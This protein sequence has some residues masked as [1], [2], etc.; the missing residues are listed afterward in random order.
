MLMFE[1]FRL[2]IFLTVVEECSFT[3]AANKLGISQPAVSQ[4]IAELEKMT[5]G[6]LFERLRG[7]VQI[8]PEGEVFEKYARGI[9]SSYAE[10]SRLFRPTASTQVAISASEDIY[11]FIL[12]PALEDFQKIH[13]HV[14]F[15]MTTPQEADLRIILKSSCDSPFDMDPAAIA[16]VRVS[17]M[18]P[19]KDMGDHKATHESLT[20]YN[21]LY[22][23]SEAFSA[24]PLSD[25]LKDY[26]TGSLS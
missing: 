15:I 3:K 2:R 19:Q 6:M 26:L 16:R 22:L 14:S 7:K 21:L 18:P 1:D 10:V 9:I 11:A 17:I 5:G 12:G 24:N 25:F 20:Y 23:P 13:P 8:T 4:N